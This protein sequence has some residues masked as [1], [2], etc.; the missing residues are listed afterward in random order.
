MRY[1]IIALICGAIFLASSSIAS[2]FPHRDKYPD[3]DIIELM[4]LKSGYDK[5]EF[6]VVDVRSIGEFETIHLKNA[7]NIPYGDANFIRDLNRLA[8]KNSDKKIAVYDNGVKCLKS[9]KAAEDAYDFAMIENVYAFDGGVSAWAESYPADTI[10][11]GSVL[12]DPKGELI[13]EEQVSKQSLTFEA[14]KEKATGADAVV[15]DLREPIQRNKNLPG[16][17]RVLPIPIE[18]LITNILQKERLKEKKLCFF[19]QVGNKVKWLMYY[20]IDNDYA[21][22]YFLEGGATAVLEEQEYRISLSK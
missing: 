2:S 19:D 6:V 15:F 9:Y 21:D 13:S 14:F 8:A 22:Y 17:K 12:K 7:V 11:F 10:L 5:G 16:M 1:V 4:D 20:L 3:V 18:K